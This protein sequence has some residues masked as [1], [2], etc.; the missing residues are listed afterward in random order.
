MAPHHGHAPSDH[1]DRGVLG[2]AA[3]DA[4]HAHGHV[5][6][7]GVARPPRG[8]GGALQRSAV[9]EASHTW[10]PSRYGISSH[11]PAAGTAARQDSLRSGAVAIPRKHDVVLAAGHDGEKVDRALAIQR[12]TPP[13]NRDRKST[14]L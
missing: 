12:T 9:V 11:H 13:I 6:V 7:I 2:T 8:K 14:R 3:L 4:P 1:S 5:G 10:T